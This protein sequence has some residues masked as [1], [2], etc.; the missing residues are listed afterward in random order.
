MVEEFSLLFP[1]GKLYRV[2]PIDMPL[3]FYRDTPLTPDIARIY[4]PV[5]VMSL[6]LT[7]RNNCFLKCLWEE[8]VC[9]LF[10]SFGNNPNNFEVDFEP[11]D[12]E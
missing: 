10:V 12:E 1:P 4:E 5:V 3:I 6:G 9:L 2:T 11:I 8:R 7:K